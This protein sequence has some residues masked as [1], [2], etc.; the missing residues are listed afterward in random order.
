LKNI[1]AVGVGISNGLKL[2]EKLSPPRLLLGFMKWFT[3]VGIWEQR[4]KYFSA[5]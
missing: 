2:S 1:Y 3:R 5:E 4:N